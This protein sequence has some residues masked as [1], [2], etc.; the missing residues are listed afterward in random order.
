MVLHWASVTG[1][2]SIDMQ[3]LCSYS[4]RKTKNTTAAFPETYIDPWIN[5]GSWETA[6]LPHPKPTFCPKWEVGDNVGLGEG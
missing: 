1:K 2:G 5:P 6:H 3:L 4:Y